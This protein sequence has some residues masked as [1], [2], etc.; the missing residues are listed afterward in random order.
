MADQS[1]LDERYFVDTNVYNCPFCN[2]RHVAYSIYDK[3]QFDWA[4]GKPCRAYFVRC[5]SCRGDSMHLTFSELSTTQVSTGASPRWRFEFA[6]GVD[7]GQALNDAFFYSVPT[8]FFV[9][10]ERVPRILRELLAE[11]EGCLKSNFLTGASACARK[12]VYELASIERAPGDSYEERIKALKG[13]HP[14]VEAAYFDTLLTLQQLTSSKVHENSYD[15]WESKH[16]RIILASLKEILHELYVV[17]ALRAD[18]RK[19]ILDLK[20]EL[21]GKAGERSSSDPDAGVT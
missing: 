20:Q 8:S 14:E 5:H 21:L 1:H 13:V 4:E 9:L 11:A 18:R 6:V 7:A 10:D 12:I 2:R 17:P 19:S 16:L 3:A 15:G